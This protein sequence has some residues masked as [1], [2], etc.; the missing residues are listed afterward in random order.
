MVFPVDLTDYYL[1]ALTQEHECLYL[2]S[3]AC[4][5]HFSCHKDILLYHIIHT[6]LGNKQ[7]NYI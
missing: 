2:Q 5:Q 3:R 4:H 7:R 6:A 1:T